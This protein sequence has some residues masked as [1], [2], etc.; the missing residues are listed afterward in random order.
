M[1]I[2]KYLAILVK[3]YLVI[4]FK[5]DSSKYFKYVI[6]RMFLKKFNKLIFHNIKQQ[7]E[8]SL[9]LKLLKHNS[10]LKSIFY[11]SIMEILWKTCSILTK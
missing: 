5:S 3:K 6:R 2:R 8:I 4:I 11:K 9:C 1:I 7:Y 10:K